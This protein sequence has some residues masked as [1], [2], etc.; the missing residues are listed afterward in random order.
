VPFGAL[1][2]AQSFYYYEQFVSQSWNTVI[3]QGTNWNANV[4]SVTMPWVGEVQLD[5]YVQLNYGPSIL[6]VQV[7]PASS[8]TPFNYWAGKKTEF[9]DN[10]GSLV[11][12]I[13]VRWT[14]LAAGTLLQATIQIR[15][16]IANGTVTAT[17]FSGSLRAQAV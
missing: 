10:G 12:P 8:I 3:P 4:G 6:G 2:S 17:G 15:V 13:F 16:G 11:C 5:G 7:W 1:P 9:A 14:S